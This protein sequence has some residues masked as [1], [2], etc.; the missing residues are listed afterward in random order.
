MDIG[1]D[2][3][4][5][6]LQMAEED[7]FD[8]ETQQKSR[9]GS[10][11]MITTLMDEEDEESEEEAEKSEADE[12]ETEAE[13][14][15]RALEN[16]LDGLYDAY[17]ERKIERDAKFKA[18]EARKKNKER[19]EEFRGF[20]ND[21]DDSDDEDSEDGGWDKTEEMKAKFGEDSS[22]S[23]SG[24]DGE[25]EEEAPVPSRKKRSRGDE[26]ES[27]SRG[28]KRAKLLTK[29]VDPKSIPAPSKTAQVWF[30]QDMFKE[31]DALGVISDD[32]QDEEEPSTEGIDDDEVDEDE[33]V[34]RE[35]LGCLGMKLTFS[36]DTAHRDWR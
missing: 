24:D 15:V 10:K 7:I 21:K 13:R 17:R 2:L 18:K 6:G 19:E 27:S 36:L 23:E 32:A 28:E 9:K 34:R 30:A 31:I 16:E 25:D 33:V 4:D 5:K 1:L 3:E 8:L 12:D 20:G 29:L 14:K 11:K 26:D 35:F 22:D